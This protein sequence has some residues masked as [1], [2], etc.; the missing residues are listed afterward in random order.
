M[1][2]VPGAE[3]L[4]LHPARRT[5]NPLAK[6]KR[7]LWKQMVATTAQRFPAM[8]GCL[9]TFGP[10]RGTGDGPASAADQ[11]IHR[12]VEDSEPRLG[13]ATVIGSSQRTLSD[14]QRTLSYLA[15]RHLWPNVPSEVLR[16]SIEESSPCL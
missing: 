11:R 12:G 4:L 15:Q 3:V 2:V 5:T 6:I 7:P 10:G 8:C 1:D 16:Y 14:F 9:G 13:V